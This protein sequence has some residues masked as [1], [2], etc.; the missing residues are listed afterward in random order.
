M[1]LVAFCAY[2]KRAGGQFGLISTSNAMV[3][4]SPPIAPPTTDHTKELS[5]HKPATLRSLMQTTA[6]R[7]LLAIGLVMGLSACIG[8]VGAS[9]TGGDTWQEEVLLHD[10]QKMVVERWA[11]RGGRS[12]VNQQA[13]IQKQSLEFTNPITRQSITWASHSSPDLRLA[14][15]TPIA[16]QVVDATPYLVAHPVGCQAYNKWG[17]PNPPYVIFRYTASAWQRIELQQLPQ[18]IRKPNLIVSSPD[19]EVQRLGTRSVSAAMIERVNGELTQPE[20]RTILREP[21]AQEQIASMC[22]ELV[23]YKGHWIDPRNPFAR[24]YID[25]KQK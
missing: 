19:N 15:L 18:A 11:S 21:M 22:D 25:E 13:A 16:L 12:E 2:L 6:R 3:A 10:G 14:D 20:F 9:G 5:M 17:R 7:T 1:K 23:N 4:F 8:A 24:K